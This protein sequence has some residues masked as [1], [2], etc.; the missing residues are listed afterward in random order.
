MNDSKIIDKSRVERLFEA[1]ETDKKIMSLFITAGYPDLE[2]TVELILGFEENGA[3]LIELGMP[4]VIRFRTAPPFSMPT[5][6]R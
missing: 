2:S 3:D 6:C 1:R 5:M 4:L